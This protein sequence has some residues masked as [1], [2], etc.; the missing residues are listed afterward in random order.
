MKKGLKCLYLKPI[1]RPFVKKIK[2]TEKISIDFSAKF[3]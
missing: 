2:E 1:L 3:L